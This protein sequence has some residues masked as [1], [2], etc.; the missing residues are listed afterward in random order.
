M[1]SIYSLY[2]DNFIDNYTPNNN[3][4]EQIKILLL[5]ITGL[6]EI[7]CIN[8]SEFIEKIFGNIS[9]VNNL[10]KQIEFYV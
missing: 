5:E 6:N 4:I 1:P 3:L 8:T 7:N 10:K 9:D 2:E